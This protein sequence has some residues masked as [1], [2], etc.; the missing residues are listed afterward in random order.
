MYTLIHSICEWWVCMNLM[1]HSNH[2]NVIPLTSQDSINWVNIKILI[3]NYGIHVVPCV[4]NW[5]SFSKY[6]NIWDGKKHNSCSMFTHQKPNK[7][8]TIH[9]NI[10][11]AKHTLLEK[12][13][14]VKMK[15]QH[16][17]EWDEEKPVWLRN[18]MFWK[19]NLQRLHTT[20]M[21]DAWLTEK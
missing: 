21:H 11:C 14:M 18:H 20:H 9:M 8:E 10:A 13:P 15:Q 7:C 16:D 12:E 17:M 19:P 2:F 6:V 3:F 1:Q 4:L 5:D